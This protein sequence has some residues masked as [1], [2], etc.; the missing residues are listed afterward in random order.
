[1]AGASHGLRLA[2]ALG[3]AAA[4]ARALC[5][6]A[7]PPDGRPPLYGAFGA[8]NASVDAAPQVLLRR[9]PTAGDDATCEGV[10][11][12]RAHHAHHARFWAARDDY[13]AAV[14]NSRWFSVKERALGDVFDHVLRPEHGAAPLP[15]SLVVDVGANIGWYSL[16]ALGRGYRVEAFDMQPECTRRARCAVAANQLAA[17]YALHTAYVT[18]DPRDEDAPPLASQARVCLGAL[19]P[20]WAALYEWRGATVDVPPLHLGRHLAR[21][22]RLHGATASARPPT[23]ATRPSSSSSSSSS[24]APLRIPLVKVDIEGGEVAVARS[25]A[26]PAGLLHAIDNVIAEYSP[27][28]W[29]DLNVSS[30]AAGVAAFGAWFAA[31]FVAVD[32]PENYAV[33]PARWAAAP[34]TPD[35]PEFG[36][37]RG[38]VLRSAGDLARYTEWALATLRRGGGAHIFT[39]WFFRPRGAG[40]GGGGA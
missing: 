2:L 6:S 28:M 22:L 37:P 14:M 3:A 13:G 21:L 33:R 40:H 25:L 11:F 15:G 10:V 35:A 32:L 4:T 8:A 29:G 18:D 39:L 9:A 36:L 20:A 19:N 7:A 16:F 26:E 38:S 31:G 24:Q 1:M 5:V 23:A 17:R 12:Y 34:D 30:T 27:H